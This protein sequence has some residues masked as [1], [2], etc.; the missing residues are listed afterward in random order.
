MTRPL[1]LPHADEDLRMLEHTWAEP[2]G[3]FGW[4]THVDHKSIARRYLVTAFAYFL[5]GGLLAAAMRLL[6]AMRPALLP[7][8]TSTWAPDLHE[9]GLRR[10]VHEIRLRRLGH[11]IRLRRLGLGRRALAC[12]RLHR[13]RRCRR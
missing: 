12:R 8:R 3:V 5:L 11:E 10:L 1:E 6:L 4:L 2:S 13:S 9:I 7:L